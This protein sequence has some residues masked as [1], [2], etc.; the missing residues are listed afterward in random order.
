M[1][2]RFVLFSKCP[3]SAIGDI[4]LLSGVQLPLS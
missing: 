4:G 3:G 2:Y 1:E